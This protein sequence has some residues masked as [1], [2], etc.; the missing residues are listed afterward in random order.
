MV[1]DGERVFVEHS[2][3]EPVAVVEPLVLYLEFQGP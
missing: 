3:K 1:W 2:A